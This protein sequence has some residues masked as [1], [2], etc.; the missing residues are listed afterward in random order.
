MTDPKVE[1]GLSAA[2]NA[3][4]SELGIN[5][6]L[7]REISIDELGRMVGFAIPHDV[8]T[9]VR[10]AMA[11]GGAAVS[12]SIT[13]LLAGAGIGSVV[14]GL[15]TIVGVAVAYLG[16]IIAD[17]LVD[18]FT[19][20]TRAG[21][22]PCT[23]KFQCLDVTKSDQLRFSPIE[24]IAASANFLEA[25]SLADAQE[26]LNRPCGVLGEAGLCIVT[27]RELLRTSVRVVD[28]TPMGMTPSDV[29]WAL[30][31]LEPAAKGEYYND[32]LDKRAVKFK[33]FSAIGGDVD[34]E[35]IVQQLHARKHY[36]TDLSDKLWNLEQLPLPLGWLRD[37]LIEEIRN[38]TFAVYASQGT[39]RLGA[40]VEYL[41]VVTAA[42]TMV[43]GVE[44][45]RYNEERTK[46]AQT[47]QP[48]VAKPSATQVCW[49][50]FYL[51]KRQNPQLAQALRGRDMFDMVAV[52]ERFQA[53]EIG[54]QQLVRSW[55]DLAWTR[56]RQYRRRSNVFSAFVD[57]AVTA[58]NPLFRRA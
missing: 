18:L 6:R 32:W 35:R 33:R 3:L 8:E 14:P 41:G 2:E 55:K 47:Q 48:V 19:E 23:A 25:A 9:V 13:G 7:P 1:Q 49:N 30:S 34:Y 20:E 52:C 37:A 44:V 36:L 10:T 5:V 56:R 51:W 28:K 12:G 16:T 54:P 39:Q 58:G 22:V 4:R 45:A 57:S 29:E 24:Y 15:G 11:A 40:N 31:V 38:A 17:V 46:V 42:L 50:M 26:Q 27:M 43:R 53:G 21:Q